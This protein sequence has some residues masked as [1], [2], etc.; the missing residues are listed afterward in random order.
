MKTKTLVYGV[1]VNDSAEPVEKRLR[2]GGR[3]L[4]I[5]ACPFHVR[6]REMLTRC[7]SEKF[8]VKHPSYI[9][10][11]VTS[12]WHLFSNFKSWMESQ[13]WQE[14]QTDKD[15]LY[16]GSRIYGPET[17]A[18]VSQQLN[19]F[20]TDHR[21]ARGDFPVGVSFHKAL[22]KFQA[23]CSNPFAGA[24]DFLG[25]FNCPLMAHE[26]WR[27]RKHQHA[28]RYADMQSDPRVAQALRTRYLPGTEHK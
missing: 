1:G 25:Y 17:C 2:I 9:G 5:W 15:I 6:W 10:C 13:P 22:R 7:Y 20:T 23:S 24:I 27:K 4:L 21:A 18:F 16:P 26:A 28:C 11:S 12:D 14:N 3:K 19:K 8:Q